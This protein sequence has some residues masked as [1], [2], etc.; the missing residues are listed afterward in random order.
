M[1]TALKGE[2]ASVSHHPLTSVATQCNPLR[3]CLGEDRFGPKAVTMSSANGH[4]TSTLLGR[5]RYGSPPNERDDRED[6]VKI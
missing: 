5:R 4:T 3:K 2:S 6:T 1:P